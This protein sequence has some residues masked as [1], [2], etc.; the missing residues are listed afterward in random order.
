[1]I[2]AQQMQRNAI[3]ALLPLVAGEPLH[4]QLSR[5]CDTNDYTVAQSNAVTNALFYLRQIE[6]RLSQ[7]NGQ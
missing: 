1:M 6:N 2:N 4:M 3:D 7:E 5:L